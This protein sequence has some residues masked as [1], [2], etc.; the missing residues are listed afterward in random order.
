MIKLNKTD[1]LILSLLQKD[2][3]MSVEAIANKVGIS[4]S[5]CWRRIQ[6]FEADGVIQGRY[7]VL[8]PQKVN[9]ALTVYISVRTNQHDDDWYKEFKELSESLIEVL[10]VHRMSGDL[11]YLLKAVVAD[12]ASYDR[13]YK[14]LV[15][16]KLLDV[17]AA[18]VMETLKQTTQLPLTPS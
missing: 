6:K 14:K 1:I 11:D 8:D 12:M 5:A 10:E 16:A 7:T 18:F 2:A 9:L 13:L 17:S 3:S 15:K 4:K